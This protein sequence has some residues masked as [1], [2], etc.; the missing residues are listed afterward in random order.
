MTINSQALNQPVSYHFAIA[1]MST[2]GN[3]QEPIPSQ[4]TLLSPNPLQPEKDQLFLDQQL[5]PRE[6]WHYDARDRI[7]TWKG[8]FGG[9][10]L[11]RHHNGLGATG[12]IGSS[13]IPCSVNASVSNQDATAAIQAPQVTKYD[14]TFDPTALDLRDL[15][16]M[17][18]F[19]QDAQG[20]W[21]DMVQKAVR[22]DL[23]TIMNSFIPTDMWNLLFPGKPQEPLTNELAQVVS[24][25]VKGVTD[26]K[27][28]YQSLG[29]AV[30]SSG[31]ANGSDPN[32]KNLNGPRAASWL[33]NQVAISPVYYAHSQVLF[34]AQWKNRFP[35]FQAYLDDQSNNASRYQSEID[36]WVKQSIED[37]QQN[38]KPDTTDPDL[39]TKLIADVTAVGDYAK[40]NAL[41][42]ALRLY[43]D[44]TQ[45]GTL[46]LIAN[47]M[48]SITGSSDGTKLARMLQ[49][50]TAILTALDPSGVF[51]QKY[52]LTLNI[53]L[54]TNILPSLFGF[55]G[56]VMDFDVI[57]LYLQKF[58]ENNINNEETQI[59]NVA[60]QLQ[61]I[62]NDKNAD[63]KLQ[64]WV[65]SLRS[66]AETSTELGSMSTIA[67]K[68]SQILRDLEPGVY[69][70]AEAIA[71][72]FI[73]GI[74]GLGIFNLVTLCKSWEKIKQNP[75]E[76]AQIILN[77]TQFG[78][79][80]VTGILV[81]GVR[82]YAIFNV[83]ELS[84]M[85]RLAMVGKLIF[86]GSIQDA[87]A[88]T[89]GLEKIGNSF[90]GYL[91]RDAFVAVQSEEETTWVTK[92]FGNSLEEFMAT[93]IGSLLVLA[94]IGVSIYAIVKGEK[95]KFTLAS[96][97]LNIASGSLMLFATLG[98]WAIATTEVSAFFSVIC[99]V[100][101]PLAILAA[102]AG[103]G[104]MIYEMF[105]MPPDPVQQF[106][107]Q[108]AQPAGFFVPSQDS[109]IDYA[110]PYIDKAQNNLMMLG[111]SLSNEDKA[112]C[113]NPDGSLTLAEQKPTP[114]FIWQA[115]T[116]GLGMS[117]IYTVAQPD[118]TQSPV[119]YYLSLMSDMSVAFQP[120]MSPSPPKVVQVSDGISAVT[121][122]WFSHPQGNAT[123]TSDGDLVSLALTFQPVLPDI[124]GNYAIEQASGWLFYTGSTVGRDLNQS[125]TFSLAMSG[126]AP[127]FLKM[128][129]LNF[130]VN[131]TPST[132]Q[133]F[134]PSFGITPSTPLT[135]ELSGDPLPAFLTFDETTGTL[136]PNG[137]K[138]TTVARTSHTL[139]VSNG[140]GS[141]N[142]TFSIKVAPP[143]AL[144]KIQAA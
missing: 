27:A 52:T 86:S 22:Q 113:C 62:L 105:E 45:S 2:V 16:R 4:I 130:W 67:F 69:D 106:V 107:N 91:G 80:I 10:R 92:V 7:L 36:Q 38:I 114:A 101:G 73:G 1:R 108:Y 81:R 95:D 50:N 63:V 49:Q 97:A 120:M 33:K 65:D 30:L 134:G 144:P 51:A 26:P 41:Y 136:T 15:E 74:V 118:P 61:Q 6:A 68:W 39:L 47:E 96:D 13:L 23:L 104:L 122:T 77:A 141:V 119:L 76:M 133:K 28:W 58:V 19:A 82:I 112:L 87:N 100:A 43:V 102:L 123:I 37:I 88:L 60:K 84:G 83:E 5:I 131:T 128:N 9:G 48:N 137:Q 46:K 94:G 8:R 85:E 14:Q 78:L 127:N 140:L 126:I 98:M 139:T 103:L 32:C 66:I 142:T 115:Q 89:N 21:E 99:V 93:R 116:D 121:Q 64:S 75:E 35:N 70:S 55:N 29:T 110:F 18:P 40:N 143:S 12:T 71:G 44:L 129:D 125:T 42:W 90:A 109:T 25:P 79:Q 24:T 138:A 57:K 72:I 34:H 117:R 135:F 59:A 3:S 124:N 111:F 31:M 20:N 54:A 53:F 17:T 11:Y 56:D 132:D